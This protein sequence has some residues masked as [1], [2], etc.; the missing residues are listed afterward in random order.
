M[1]VVRAAGGPLALLAG[2][3]AGIA[4]G[5]RLGPA[6]VEG[7]IGAALALGA[8]SLFARG[9]TRLAIA[10]LACGLVGTAAMQRALNG[11]ARSPLTAEVARHARVGARGTLVDDP[12]AT[13]FATRVLLR[14]T[15][16]DAGRGPRRAGGRT[17]L[18]HAH[19]P[20]GA[21]LRV[22]EAG[23]RVELVGTLGPLDGNDARFRWRHAVGALVASDV[24]TFAP[25]S[26]QG[27]RVANRARALVTAGGAALPAM[28]RGLLAGFLLGDRRGLAPST[29]RNFRDAGLTHLLAVS[30]ENVAFALALAAPLLRRLRLGARFTAG[31]AVLAVFGT[32]TR[33]EPSVLRAC[34]MA[35]GVMLA[36]LL[37]RPAAALRVLALAA[38]VLLGAD[39][40][41]LHSVG[42]LLSCAA[43]AGIALLSAPIERRLPGP[44]GLREPL[45]VTI[46]AQL[47]VAP[48]L[49]PVFGSMPLAALP[50]NVLA[51]PLVGPLTVWGLASGVAGGL[52]R[53]RLPGL[54]RAMQLPNLALL[55]AIE[56]IAAAGARV[57][58][59]IDGRSA[60]LVVASAATFAALLRAGRA[61]SGRLAADA[62]VPPR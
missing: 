42:F 26:S 3:V 35:A 12:D 6:P 22:L 19:G 25:P 41:L 31:L 53:T 2:L 57:P 17:L 13:Q 33:W 60:W 20:V 48:L 54:A 1:A 45:S 23:D 43:T 36:S 15:S 37:G 44:R 16:V 30:G 55:R 50:A 8:V 28:E 21:R 4:L 59:R 40:F 27:W 32:M 11:L 38:A 39:P 18:V 14:I 56:G 61:R 7:A 34:A 10:V 52:V 46:A 58:A 62:P 24:R 9:R 51:A 47:G 29:A 49:I 5:E